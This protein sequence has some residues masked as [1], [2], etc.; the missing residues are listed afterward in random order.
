[1]FAA[2][3]ISVGHAS[4]SRRSHGGRPPDDGVQKPARCETAQTRGWHALRLY[5]RDGCSIGVSR[6][7]KTRRDAILHP[8]RAW[9]ASAARCL[10]HRRNTP[11]L[12]PWWFTGYSY[13]TVFA[14]L[15][16]RY[17]M[18]WLC[19]RCCHARFYADAGCVD[20]GC[21]FFRMFQRFRR[22]LRHRLGTR[23]VRKPC[24]KPA[25]FGCTLRRSDFVSRVDWFLAAGFVFSCL[26]HGIIHWGCNSNSSAEVGARMRCGASHA[27]SLQNKLGS[28]SIYR[29]TPH[30]SLH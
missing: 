3:L 7:C 21:C 17:P 1:M 29:R 11:S 10:G 14:L 8:S 12:S 9:G 13:R 2:C 24:D 25:A 16:L 27:R 26:G 6:I 18:H 4:L 5:F 22:P 19:I 23:G 28:A 15:E 20:P 30:R